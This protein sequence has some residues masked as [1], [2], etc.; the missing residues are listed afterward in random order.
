MGGKSTM[1]DGGG[2]TEAAA[3]GEVHSHC[4]LLLLL[5]LLRADLDF[6]YAWVPCK[7]KPMKQFTPARKWVGGPGKPADPCPCKWKAKP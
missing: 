2:V 5:P 4:R 6:Q 7:W 3:C 1:G